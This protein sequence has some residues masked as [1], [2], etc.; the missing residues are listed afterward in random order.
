MPAPVGARPAILPALGSEDVDEILQCVRGL[1]KNLMK[2]RPEEPE[3]RLLEF[4]AAA[5]EEE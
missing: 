2:E 1:P 4:I 5:M 3:R